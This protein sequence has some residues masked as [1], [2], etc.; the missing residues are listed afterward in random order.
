ML[1]DSGLNNG[2]LQFISANESKI[3]F[4]HAG[5]ITLVAIAKNQRRNDEMNSSMVKT[6]DHKVE[7]YPS[8]NTGLFTIQHDDCCLSHD[9]DDDDEDDGHEDEQ[10]NHN[11]YDY[12]SEAILKLL[13]EHL[14]SGII[15]TLT[16]SVQFMLEQNPN[17]DVREILGSSVNVLRNV[18]NDMSFHGDQSCIFLGGVDVFGPIPSEVCSIYYH[19]HQDGSIYKYIYI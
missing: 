18:L 17:L 5:C 16:D 11:A 6:Y 3:C 4:M 12:Y 7:Q 9:D 14:Y 10:N 1:N 13:L 2:D 19:F 8:P 15:Y